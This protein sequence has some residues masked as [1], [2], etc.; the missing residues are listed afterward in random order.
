M[1]DLSE[2]SDTKKIEKLEKFMMRNSNLFIRREDICPVYGRVYQII[3][4]Y[5]NN[6]SEPLFLHRYQLNTRVTLKNMFV[7]PSFSAVNV[8]T[9]HPDNIIALLDSFVWDHDKDRLLFIDGDAAIGKTSLISWL[10]YHYTELDD[11]GKSIFVDL[12]LV[13]VRL[14]DLS[15]TKNES[16]ETCI[17]Q[18]LEIK[19]IDEFEERF[20]N[21]LIVLEG[22]DE[23]GLVWGIGSLTIEQFILDTRHAFF[24]HKIIITSRPKFINMDVF[25]RTTQNFSYQH[26]SL[27]HF[28]KEKRNCWIQNYENKEKCGEI[29]SES[30]KQ[31]LSDLSD[32]EAAGVADTPLA[33]YLLVAC[34]ITVPL[35]NNKWALYH[36]IFHN[37]I[38]N[39]PYNESFR[40]GKNTQYH[41]ALKDDDFAEN[42][43]DIIGRIANKMFENFKE[44][45][46]YISSNELDDIISRLYIGDKS[47]KVKA[48]RK[49]CVL[50]AYWKENTNMGALEFYHNNIRDFFMCEYI[51]Q[52]FFNKTYPSG[53]EDI[54]KQLIETA[55]EVFQYGMIAKTTWTQTFSFLYFRL[56]Y[57]K[58][59]I[60]SEGNI[61]RSLHIV[62]LFPLIVY[63]MINNDTMWKYPFNGSQYE[64]IKSTFLNFVLFLRIWVATETSEPLKIFLED[65]YYEFWHGKGIFEDW[66]RIFSDNIDITNKMHIA[67]GS[68]MM[69]SNMDFK[70]ANLVSA[71][72]EKS[73]FV[74]SNFEKADLSYANYSGAKLKKVIF[75][76]AD[77]YNV[78]FSNSTLVEVDFSGANL[79]GAKFTNALIKDV[80]WPEKISNLEEADFSHAHI[81]KARW[82]NWKLK[83]VEFYA[84]EFED[85][86]FHRVQFFASASNA[87]FRS[88]SITNTNFES[89]NSVLYCGQESDLSSINFRGDIN[90]CYFRDVTLN[91]SSWTDANVDNIHFINVYIVNAEFRASTIRR[92]IFD[93]CRIEGIDI[94]RARISDFVAS[95]LK[96]YAKNIVNFRTAV[97]YVEDKFDYDMKNGS[98]E[99]SMLDI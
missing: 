41:Q 56:Q 17:L 97:I 89:I 15:F 68:Q 44:E 76:G 8:F 24:K 63:S 60:M 88:C 34:E 83:N 22:A 1:N 51:Y 94:Y 98:T 3:N 20:G 33:L 31:Y 96:K 69:F 21:A 42:V 64:S 5:T 58:N 72:F 46:F 84:T 74:D 48:I 54:I 29:I 36:E 82:K 61:V 81:C 16:A 40:S 70:Q 92:I 45:R 14:R 27:N 62:K 43:Y 55:C 47:E 86:S 90:E 38:R 71:C 30:T 26:Y 85:C 67:F 87:I 13:C 80:I 59:F 39:T 32:E 6:F 23:L 78:D 75:T 12:Q 66:I 79:C 2:E 57:E 49:C 91:N 93:G 25:S 73:D 95:Y 35:R 53:T 52:H 19:D 7:E 50:C 65:T 28:L 37:A 11:I 10:C 77:L 99:H 9:Q 18:Y 4:E